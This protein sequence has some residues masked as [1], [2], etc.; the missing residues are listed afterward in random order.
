MV[1]VPFKDGRPTGEYRT[2]LQGA[3]STTIRPIGLAIGADGA[4]YVGSDAQGK[5][6]KVT[7]TAGH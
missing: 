4:L 3:G 2:F 1:Y 6:W 7:Y 5:I